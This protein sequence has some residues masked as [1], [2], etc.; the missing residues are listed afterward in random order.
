MDAAPVAASSSSPSSSEAA[1]APVAAAAPLAVHET[2]GRKVKFTSYHRD[3]AS[4]FWAYVRIAH[5]LL[6]LEEERQLLRRY[7]R[8]NVKDI[9]D[10]G[11][12]VYKWSANVNRQAA[13]S[14]MAARITDGEYEDGDCAADF[15]L[16]TYLELYEK[17]YG[18][19]PWAVPLEEEEEEEEGAGGSARGRKTRKKAGDAAHQSAAAAA[20]A[21]G[22]GAPKRLTRAQTLAAG[23]LQP[24]SSSDLNTLIHSLAF[25]CARRVLPVAESSLVPDADYG[26][27]PAVLEDAGPLDAAG[28]RLWMALRRAAEGSGQGAGGSGGDG[29]CANGGSE[30]DVGVPG[31]QPGSTGPGGIQ[32]METLARDL[33]TAFSQ[34]LHS[35]PFPDAAKTTVYARLQLMAVM[36]A[37]EVPST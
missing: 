10:P 32:A 14:R 33:T 11:R 29:A 12:C 17:N 23:L 27:T 34:H 24:P 4:A 7:G 25:A 3:V 31:A 35:Y 5:P 15:A 6:S 36:F 19:E 2:A 13:L 8:Y 9:P 30:G 1:P 26:V 18:H 16:D 21:P 22:A 28:F 20:L 37:A